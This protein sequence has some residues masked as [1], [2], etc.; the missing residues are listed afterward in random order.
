MAGLITLQT[1]FDQS[2]AILGNRNVADIPN[3]TMLPWTN[4][5]LD[6]L[7]SPRVY[8]HPE[9]WDLTSQTLVAATRLYT[10]DTAQAAV[11]TVAV[12]SAVIVSSTDATQR[13]RLRPI[14]M[15]DGFAAAG[16]VT[17]GTPLEYSLYSATQIELY[18]TPSSGYSAW[19]L[20][21]RRIKVATQFTVA[22]IATEK[23]PL[24]RFFDE[25]IVMGTV[26]RGWR[27]LKETL[28][29][30]AAKA[31]FAQCVNEI[32][33]RLSLEAEDR[34]FGPEVYVEESMP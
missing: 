14:R 21:I 7:S 13:I 23:S 8:R 30:E 24:H 29:A 9:L 26:W 34:D 22:G 3:A 32:T 31:E 11:D 16:R 28:R 33:D 17:A 19:N 12:L 25:A 10:I 18:P 20:L 4:W 27:H 5:A 15:R 2:R 1:I 6:Q